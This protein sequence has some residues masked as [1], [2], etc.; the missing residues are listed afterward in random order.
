[1]ARPPQFPLL[2]QGQE[3][4][5]FSNGSLD[6]SSNIRIWHGPYTR[7]PVT[8][9]SISIQRPTSFS[10]VYRQ[11]PWLTCLQIYEYYMGA[12]QLYLWCKR[13]F[14]ISPY[15]L[16]LC[17]SYIGLYNPL[18]NFRF[19]AFVWN[20]CPKVFE[21]CQCFKRMA[22]ALFVFSLVLSALNTLSR[23]CRDSARAS[24]SCSFSAKASMICKPQIGNSSA[25]YAN[26][27][28]MF[29]QSI[30]YILFEKNVD[31]LVGWLVVL[32]LTAL[33]D[34]ISVYIGPSPKEREKEERKDRWEQTHPHLLQNCRTP[35]HW[36]FTQHHRTTRPPPKN[37][38]EGGWKKTS[39]PDSICC[40]G[41]FFSAAIH[42]NC[43]YSLIVQVFS[44]VS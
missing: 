43:T 39:L 26:L 22:L 24:S 35:R 17:Q 13:Y 12:H 1:M 16:Q 11:S 8:F 42:M 18:E 19:W 7:C 33:W 36:K 40:S 14:V 31:W 2:D 23:F 32:G 5:I 41:P 27:S 28:I 44:G 34:S 37:V 10:P 21:A 20:N 6:L 3:F 30:R 4:V 9:G 25:A 38:E 15:W 29:F